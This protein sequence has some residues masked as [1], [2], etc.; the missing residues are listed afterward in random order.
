MKTLNTCVGIDL[1]RRSKHKAVIACPD[2]SGQ[3]MPQRA[4]SFSHDLDGFHAVYTRIIRQTGNTSLEGVTVNMEPTSGVWETVGA[5]FASRG[6]QVCFTRPDIVSQL[7]KVHSKFAKTD[8]IDA[9]TLAGIP[10]SF[11][12]RLVPVVTIEPRIR[13]LR[14]LAAQRLRLVEDQTRWKNRFTAKVETVW[15]SLLAQLEDEQRFSG[16][17]RAFFAKY[18]NPRKVLR[19]GRK[20]FLTWC[21]NNAHGNTSARL[22]ELMWTSAEQATALWNELQ[23][24]GTLTMNWQCSGD[25]LQQ[26]LRLIEHLEREIKDVE[27]RI[28]EA[29]INVPEC[30]LL[31]QLP[32]VAQVVSVTL[33]GILMPVE[34]F[35]NTKKCGA[36][37]GFT[38]RKKASAGREIQGLRITK[39]GNRRLKRDL[40]LAADTAMH[41][42]PELADFA[43]RLLNLGK[44]Y[45][46][47][48]VAVGRKIAVRAY[49]LLKR[50]AANPDTIFVW[51]DLQGKT[52]SK[53]RAK[54]LAK[55]LWAKH[56]ANKKE[57][58]ARQTAPNRGRPKAP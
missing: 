32:G 36:Y 22:F 41:L 42:D 12:E 15:G 23:A 10:V 39:S 33:A 50:Y 46:K 27:K 56:K 37:T 29:R 25:L 28:K 58:E 26:D 52:I 35:A 34:R 44:H 45:N 31:E 11:P 48:R 9:R 19:M 55:A 7:R 17:F 3:L 30:D 2:A 13:A 43:I 49:S 24:A 57:K 54:A 38:G 40:A 14:D 51:R 53:Q 20:R 4:F 1:A 47:V 18:Y 6:A 21:A 16:L 5:F 8:R